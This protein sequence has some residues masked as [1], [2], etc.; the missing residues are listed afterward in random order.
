MFMFKRKATMF[1]FKHKAECY[2]QQELIETLVDLSHSLVKRSTININADIKSNMSVSHLL[3]QCSV[4][5][6]AGRQTGQTKEIINYINAHR[7]EY[8]FILICNNMSNVN[9]IKKHFYLCEKTKDGKW[10]GLFTS[11]NNVNSLFDKLRGITIDRPLVIFT[12]CLSEKDR[13]RAVVKVYEGMAPIY[14]KK[15]FLHAAVHI[16]SI[17]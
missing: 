6:T 5:F 4:M 2:I 14:K 12:D 3:E 10:A 13:M 1:T 7:D 17:I 8:F 9:Y 11:H 16:G 15:D